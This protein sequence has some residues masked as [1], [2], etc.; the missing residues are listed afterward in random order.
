MSCLVTLCPRWHGVYWLQ[1]R[2]F[3]CLYFHQIFQKAKWHKISN[4][5]YPMHV[6]L[7]M[8]GDMLIELHL[9]TYRIGQAVQWKIEFQS[10]S[11]SILKRVVQGKNISFY[12]LSECWTGDIWR[13][14]I[15]EPIRSV[16]LCV[17]WWITVVRYA[18]LSSNIPCGSPNI[19]WWLWWG[20][21]PHLHQCVR[22]KL[23]SEGVHVSSLRWTIYCDWNR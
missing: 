6:N 4:M 22:E 18:R 11:K 16:V 12:W 2:G 10:K 23:C 8:L 21:L 1:I 15:G 9:H 13:Q 5:W 7:I 19:D 3:G 14:R 17:C 20:T